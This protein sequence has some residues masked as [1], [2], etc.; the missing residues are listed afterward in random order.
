[1]KKSVVV[2]IAAVTLALVGAGRPA[3]ASTI[4]LYDSLPAAGTFNLPSLAYQGTQTSQFGELIQLTAS[5][6]FDLTV[7]VAMSNWSVESAYQPV[8]TSAGFFHDLTFNLFDVGPGNTVGSAIASQTVAAFIPWRPEADPTC[9]TVTS[10]RAGDLECYTGSLS[11]VSFSF[12]GITVPNQL[13]YGLAYNT[14]S[15]GENP[16]GTA[17][18]FN[19]LNFGLTGPPTVGLNVLADTAYWDTAIAAFYTDGGAGG[20]GVFRADTLWDPY[21]GAVQFSGAEVPE[22][23]SMLL[24]GA[25]LVGVARKVRRRLTK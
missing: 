3:S 23:T 13:I 20:V 8:G 18:P 4:L 16:I 6:Q 25:G 2:A 21:N 24:L 15:S 14:Q 9:P 22:P 10:W 12:S 7:T 19:S 5:G 17:G 11:Q 1:M